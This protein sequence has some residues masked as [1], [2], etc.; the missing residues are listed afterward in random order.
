M[1]RT[2]VS[3]DS[4]FFRDCSFVVSIY[5]R[6]V[7]A[8]SLVGRISQLVD[9]SVIMVPSCF[10][11]WLAHGTIHFLRVLDGRAGSRCLWL[12]V[13]FQFYAVG[14]TVSHCSV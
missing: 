5:N 1:L 12:G 3:G 9:C 13:G 10:E 2:A 14:F 6:S 7:L 11:R 4:V 8:E